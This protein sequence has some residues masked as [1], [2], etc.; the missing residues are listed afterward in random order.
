LHSTKQGDEPLLGA[1]LAYVLDAASRRITGYKRWAVIFGVIAALPGIVSLI[2]VWQQN[3]VVS[4]ETD[5]TL[6]DIRNRSR[7]D[8]LL[9]VYTSE[10]KD[11]QTA[12][13][14]PT[15]ASSLRKEAALALIEMDS[16]AYRAA[17]KSRDIE[18]DWRV[19]LSIAPLERVNFSPLDAVEP[20]VME[21]VSFMNS[22]LFKSSFAHCHLTK[23]WFDSATL[24]QTQFDGAVLSDCAFIGA[25]LIDV[26]FS[27]AA[28]VRCD[29]KGAQYN[30]GTRW[31]E[32]FDPVAA[33]AQL[34]P[35]AKP[36]T[37]P[38]R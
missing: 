1:K 36:P 2:L 21:R 29:F 16:N 3:R 35:S 20:R 34:I 14:T 17:E 27:K 18:F 10:E 24:I 25:K 32:G 38:A 23:I 11:A 19:D 12:L 13:M 4:R 15:H 6:A 30:E 9:I 31:P 37:P 7:L 26:D 28:F 33:G 5:N 22:N 8:Q